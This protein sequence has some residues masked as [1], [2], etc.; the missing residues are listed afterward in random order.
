MGSF[1][2]LIPGEPGAG[3]QE[4]VKLKLVV[5]NFRAARKAHQA[6]KSWEQ[7][8]RGPQVSELLDTQSCEKLRAK[9]GLRTEQPGTRG[10]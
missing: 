2:A 7:R 8:V 4:T 9:L 3:L 5:P 1:K 6:Q 10:M